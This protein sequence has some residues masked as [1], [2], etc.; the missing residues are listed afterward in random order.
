MATN[1]RP[2]TSGTVS[3]LVLAD[4]L[5][6]VLRSTEPHPTNIFNLLTRP[7]VCTVS[8]LSKKPHRNTKK[9]VLKTLAEPN[10]L[11]GKNKSSFPKMPPTK[12]HKPKEKLQ[13]FT[14]TQLESKHYRIFRKNIKNYSLNKYLL[15]ATMCQATTRDTMMKKMPGDLSILVKWNCMK[16]CWSTEKTCRVILANL[17]TDAPIVIFL[18]CLLVALKNIGTFGKFMAKQ[19]VI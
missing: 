11:W 10:K 19:L 5:L 4:S 2:W 1:R 9:S 18:R 7:L 17:Q 6:W 16:W 3:T 14:E 13:V 15:R 12:P 8:T